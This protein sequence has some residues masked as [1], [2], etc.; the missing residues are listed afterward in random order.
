MEYVW[1]WILVSNAGTFAT[2][3]SYDASGGD[4]FIDTGGVSHTGHWLKLNTPFR[5]TLNWVDL[6]A[7]NSLNQPDS[8][9]ILGSGN[10]GTTW[11]LLYTETGYNMSSSTDT[12]SSNI[13]PPVD[14][15]YA[16]VNAQNRYNTFLFIFKSLRSSGGKMHIKVDG[17]YGHRENDLVRL[18]DPTNVL[19][20]PH[21][22]MTGPA[23]RGYVASA[24]SNFDTYNPWEAF[25]N[26]TGGGWISV[27]GTNYSGGDGAYNKSPGSLLGTNSVTG[28]EIRDGEFL[29][30][31][32]P[33]KIAVNHILISSGSGDGPTDFKFWGSNDSSAWSLLHTETNHTNGTSAQVDIN[34][35]VAYK[36]HAIVISKTR[37]TTQGDYVNVRE[38][39]LYGTEENSSIPIQI[40]GGNIDKVANFRVYD[41]FVGEDQALEI[42]DAQKDTFRGVKN[43]MTL[44]KGRLGIGTTEPEGRLAVADE[45]HNLEEFPPRAMTGYKNIL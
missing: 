28:T 39:E 27:G 26:N 23:Q 2:S 29:Q 21:I 36:Y 4:T 6:F 19:K 24:S 45:P 37:R 9:V 3:G 14:H 35:S 20:Y 22:A 8:Y 30:I 25:D 31:E 44:H 16:I 1:G 43:S 13:V 40:G 33:H 38:L 17:F 41:K 5:F 15:D 42:W 11:D 12:N 10:D 18:P 34:S 7:P 32:T